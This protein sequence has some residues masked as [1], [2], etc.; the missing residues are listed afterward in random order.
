MLVRE[1]L[2]LLLLSL[3]RDIAC[4]VFPAVTFI[5]HVLLVNGPTQRWYNFTTPLLEWME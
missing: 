3:H 4:I 5:H 2:V 1:V